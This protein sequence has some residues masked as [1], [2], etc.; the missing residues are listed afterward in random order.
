MFANENPQPH[1]DNIMAKTGIPNDDG[2]TYKILVLGDSN[3]GKTCL[4]HRYC[5]QAFFEHYIST[6]GG[7]C[8]AQ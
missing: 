1:F 5:D 6:I 8:Y 4:I 3:V 7:Y 2:L